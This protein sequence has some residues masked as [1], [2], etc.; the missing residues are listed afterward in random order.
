MVEPLGHYKLLREFGM[1][2]CSGLTGSGMVTVGASDP[3]VAL[4]PVEV[5]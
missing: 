3:A 4:V 2:P 5:L 1:A